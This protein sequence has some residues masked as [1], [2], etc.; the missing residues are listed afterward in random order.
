MMFL[1]TYSWVL[2]D[3]GGSKEAELSDFMN[4]P[5]ESTV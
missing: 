2:F 1:T 4:I 3:A 5:R